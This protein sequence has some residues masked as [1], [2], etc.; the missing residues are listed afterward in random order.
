M[1]HMEQGVHKEQGVLSLVAVMELFLVLCTIFLD[2]AFKAKF[3]TGVTPASFY[4]KKNVNIHL[5]GTLGV[6]YTVLYKLMLLQRIPE[7]LFCLVERKWDL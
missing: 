2:M 6:L 1:V 4:Q 3:T 5:N 7:E